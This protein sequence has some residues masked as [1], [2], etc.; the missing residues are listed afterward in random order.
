MNTF[1]IGMADYYAEDV[2][3]A[4]S[5][6]E[7]LE[8]IPRQSMD[9]DNV[10]RDSSDADSDSD[11][12][13]LL[14]EEDVSESAARAKANA[15]ELETRLRNR[16]IYKGHE[17]S[18]ARLR[19][20]LFRLKMLEDEFKSLRAEI[21]ADTE[22]K[23]DYLTSNVDRLVD[24]IAQVKI[25]DE[26]WM[27]YWNQK[28]AAL[29]ADVDSDPVVKTVTSPKKTPT[30][31]KPLDVATIGQ[32]DTRLGKLESQFAHISST[33]SKLSI[34]DTI[35]DLYRKTNVLL[36]SGGSIDAVET[37][38]RALLDNC[39][40]LSQKSKHLPP[41]SLTEEKLIHL[42]KRTEQL[43]KSEIVIPMI[44]ERLKSVNGIVMQGANKVAFLS[45]LEDQFERMDTQLDEWDQKLEA[46]EAKLDQL[47][48]CKA[49]K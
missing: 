20:R 41:P 43:P 6:E 12:D 16:L 19:N 35:D 36:D 49:K 28:F 4:E 18:D 47:E 5:E 26:D 14:I 15:Q 32:I 45:N 29:D 8:V 42:Y 30:S 22:G 31:V 7:V 25:D 34:Q 3:A 9:A 11:L 40:K 1:L 46:L 44:Y 10:L 17:N 13:K 38:V 23:N 33:S 21:H 2:P 37:R 27:N 39:E 48:K 24:E